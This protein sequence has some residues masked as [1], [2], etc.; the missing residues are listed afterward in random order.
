M[1]SNSES[2]LPGAGSL[3]KTCVSRWLRGVVATGKKAGSTGPAL[4]PPSPLPPAG[5]LPPRV[6]PLP[7]PL[8]PS[9]QQFRPQRSG[10][11]QSPKWEANLWSIT[12]QLLSPSLSSVVGSGQGIEPSRGRG[13]ATPIPLPPALPAFRFNCTFYYFNSSP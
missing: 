9:S 2:S 6:S 12:P 7:H 10:A 13:R 4:H 8:P 11:R 3:L 1:N 5:S